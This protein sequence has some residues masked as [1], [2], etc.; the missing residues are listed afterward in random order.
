MDI[1]P[2]FETKMADATYRELLQ[3]YQGQ[4]L[5]PDHV[6][7]RHIARVTSRLL[8]SSNLGTLRSVEP[9][10][11]GLGRTEDV[12]PGVGGREWTLMVVHDDKVPNAMTAY[13]NVVVFTGILPIAKDEDGLAAVLGHEIGHTVARHTSERYSS[14]KFLIIVV[15]ALSALTGI[16]FGLTRMASTLLLELPNNRTQEYEADKLGLQI[17]AKACY[18]PQAAPAMFQRLGQ[19]EG[20]RKFDFLSTHPISDKRTKELEALLPEAYEARAASA[21]CA[22]MAKPRMG[23]GET[24]PLLGRTDDEFE[25][26]DFN[27][28]TNLISGPAFMAQIGGVALVVAIWASIFMHKLSLFSA[29]PL[30]NSLGIALLLESTLM[31]QPTN[32]AAQKRKGAIVHSILNSIAFLAMYSAFIIV[33][34]AKSRKHEHHFTSAHSVFGIITYILILMQATVGMIQFYFPS[35]VGG[36]EKAKSIYKYHRISGYIIFVFI[37]MTAIA[38]TYTDFVA[39]VLKI[40][41]WFVVLCSAF[42]LAGVLPRVEPT[43]FGF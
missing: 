19:L 33:I 23:A 7:T 15:Q 30:L 35:L 11:A 32:T 14:S 1:N 6:L 37:I 9:H 43:K 21:A 42:V 20:G 3:T 8:E 10:K 40:R 5:P 25:D 22:G 2:K 18:D 26:V 12:A 31:L 38:V 39:H 28:W 16:D 4:L 41:T 34:I 36:K 17:M 29:H 24:E 27:L 13:G